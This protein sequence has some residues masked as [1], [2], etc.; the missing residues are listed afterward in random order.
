MFIL[1]VALVCTP[2]ALTMQQHQTSRTANVPAPD[3]ARTDAGHA[4]PAPSPLVRDERTEPLPV[5]T[6]DNRDT[7]VRFPAQS[8][9]SDEHHPTPPP[10]QLQITDSGDIPA[11]HQPFR[12]NTN[13]PVQRVITNGTATL[14]SSNAHRVMAQAFRARFNRAP[15]SRERQELMRLTNRYLHSE[16]ARTV[17]Q[18]LSE[19]IPPQTPG[20]SSGEQGSPSVPPSSS[21]SSNESVLPPPGRERP[22]YTRRPPGRGTPSPDVSSSSSDRNPP[23]VRGTAIPSA[24]E[25]RAP[26]SSVPSGVRRDVPGPS[27]V[28]GSQPPGTVQ[29]PRSAPTRP[30]APGPRLS[31][32]TSRVPPMRQ[33]NATHVGFEIEI[34][35]GYTFPE[36]AK[37]TLQ[38][39]L[40]RTLCECVIIRTVSGG[41][42]DAPTERRQVIL[43]MLLDD[44][45]DISRQRVRAQVEFRTTPLAFRQIDR[46][47]HANISAAIRSF[48]TAIITSPAE[49]P[50]EINET[51]RGIWRPTALL[52]SSQEQLSNGVS[53]RAHYSPPSG[54]MAQHATTSIEMDAY[55]RLS[56]DHQ[57]RLYPQGEG[58]RNKQQLLERIAAATSGNRDVST[59]GRN[60][61]GTMAKTPVESILAADPTLVTPMEGQSSGRMS[62]NSSASYDTAPLDTVINDIREQGRFPVMQGENHRGYRAIAEKLQPPLEDTISG[63]LRILV[64]HRGSRGTLQG[65]VNQA[66]RGNTQALSDFMRT[67]AEMDRQR[68]PRP[69]SQSTSPVSTEAMP[70][71]TDSQPIPLTGSPVASSSVTEATSSS[72]G[73]G[74]SE[75]HAEG[76]LIPHIPPPATA[77]SLQQLT[78]YY[79]AGIFWADTQ[80]TYSPEFLEFRD[81]LNTSLTTLQQGGLN[82]T[83]VNH[84]RTTLPG[85][86]LST[87]H[88]SDEHPEAQLQENIFDQLYAYPLG[89]MLWSLLRY[90]NGRQPQ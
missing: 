64:E 72:S 3:T 70:P 19:V 40:N 24:R 83:T 34:G 12:V 79:T 30:R 15:N 65:A 6:T 23:T 76:G 16:A 37:P 2:Y 66:L 26:S 86:I 1:E 59:G 9:T 20:S 51:V 28:T 49:T 38:L 52:L 74:T 21:A 54:T 73:I 78:A 84:I 35:A 29:V 50:F 13:S 46:S 58:A 75:H 68:R 88:A 44:I 4:L 43:E 22:E 10:F 62:V 89:R 80:G 71:L 25:R 45:T 60:F 11:Q 69:V 82:A 27:S 7:S 57:K 17:D 55:S 87:P 63:E 5:V 33:D 90:L 36:D 47:L 67:A 48:P 81:H 85:L 31:G 53:E 56:N 8:I 18:V 61:A 32:D 77:M 41:S 14:D 39:V 42:R